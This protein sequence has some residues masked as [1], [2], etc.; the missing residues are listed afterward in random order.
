[1][2]DLLSPIESR[3]V[4]RSGTSKPHTIPIPTGTSRLVMR[5]PKAN[6]NVEDDVRI[7]N[8]VAFLALARQAMTELETPLVPAVFSW[9]DSPKKKDGIPEAFC[10][11]LEEF[12]EGESMN[13]DELNALSAAQQRV[14]C[15]QLAKAVKALQCYTL[16]TGITGYGGVTFD[17]DGN[18]R[19]GRSIF[20]TGGPFE[21]YGEYLRATIKW[22]L[23]Q[24][25]LVEPINGWRNRPEAPELRRRIDAFLDDGLDKLLSELP[26]YKLALVHGDLSTWDCSAYGMDT[27]RNIALP[28]LL[29]DRST[30]RL[31]AI[32]DFDFGHIAS[33]LTEFLYSFQDFAGLLTGAAEPQ[34]GLRELI[35]H[36]SAASQWPENS[37]AGIWN[38]ALVSENMERPSVIPHAGEVADIWWFGQELLYF[39]WLLP[40]AV[41]SMSE[42]YKQKSLANSAK[43]LRVYLS[44]W[45]Y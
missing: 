14:V 44:K 9:N 6:N 36:N 17:D 15:Q 35:L 12:K 30:Q 19:S 31:T 34:D 27:D 18:F 22:Q 32:I 26:T 28:N 33:P 4:A 29:F 1:M 20:Q 40:R 11:I 38:E 16:P 43:A 5:I 13:L 10:Y 45:G 39:H 42:E 41:A 7:R 21:T 25:E 2:I 8:E 3:L 37:I 23:S 24:S